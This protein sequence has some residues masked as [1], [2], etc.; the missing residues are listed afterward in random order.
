MPFDF[1]S[2]EIVKDGNIQLAVFFSCLALWLF[3]HFGG[4]AGLEWLL[5]WIKVVLII[6]GCFLFVTILKG[7]FRARS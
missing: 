6:S 7:F 2:L 1:K 5:P 4:L 3:G